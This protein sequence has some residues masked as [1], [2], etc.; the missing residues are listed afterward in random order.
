MPTPDRTS[1]DDIV[2]AGRAIL[3]A[4]GLPKLTMQAVAE[5]VGVRAPSLYKRVKNRDD[6][7]RLIVASTADELSDRLN[8]VETAAHHT[9]EVQPDARATL[10]ALAHALRGFAHQYPAAFAL[11]FAAVPASTPLNRQSLERSI[12]P[13]MRVTAELAGPENALEAARTVTAW[14]NG[15]ISME[16]AGAFQLGGDVDSA[17]DFGITHLADALTR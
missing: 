15:F 17:F 13:V 5:R 4:D 11:I 8:A 16:L 12:D 7:I 3:E 9:I 1:L 2:R 6:L 10:I 14:A